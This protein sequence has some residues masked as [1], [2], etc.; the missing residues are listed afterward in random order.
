VKSIL[1]TSPFWFTEGRTDGSS[2]ELILT[3]LK[4]GLPTDDELARGVL[5]RDMTQWAT[6]KESRSVRVLFGDVLFFMRRPEWTDHVDPQEQFE[7]RGKVRRMTRS[8]E[9]DF[10]V[11]TRGATEVQS[12]TGRT[13]RHYRVYGED[14]IYE[15]MAAEPPLIELVV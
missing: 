4:P 6:E 8:R 13:Y 12:I 5:G 11:G 9:L 1:D 15:V 2:L 7:E 14:W 3:E 10:L